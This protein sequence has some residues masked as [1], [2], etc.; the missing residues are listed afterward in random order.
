[1]ASL[2]ALLSDFGLK[3]HYVGTVHGVIKETA[4]EAEVVDITHQVRPFDVVDGAL[5]LY[6]SYRYFPTG[7]IFLCMVDPDPTAELV[8][9]STEKFFLVCPNNG[10]GSLMLEEEPPIALYKITADHYFIEGRGNFRTRNQLAPI[11][12]ELSR[13][14]SAVYLGEELEL[15]NLKRFKLPEPQKVGKGVYEAIVIDADHFGN[16]ILNFKFQ[17]EL[18][19]EAE[20]NGVR[21]KG[22]SCEFKGFKRGQLFISVNPENHLQIVAYMA[23][24]AKLLKVARGAKVKLFF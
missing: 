2:I 24:A 13:L 11:A 22:S 17:G 7:T 12:A 4:P 14:Q 15:K 6:W 3:D 10:I 1:M 16:L 18:P 23:S 8:I 21:I 5:K 20:V 9:V 19:K